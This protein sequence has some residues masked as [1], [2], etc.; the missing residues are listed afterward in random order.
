MLPQFIFCRGFDP[1]NEITAFPRTQMRG[2]LRGKE[3]EEG[4]E[5]ER[6]EEMSPIKNHGYFPVKHGVFGD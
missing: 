6:K 5:E 4:R 1:R 3:G 2:P